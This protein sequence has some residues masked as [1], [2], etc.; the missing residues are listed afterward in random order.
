MA[1]YTI[2]EGSPVIPQPINDNFSYLETYIKN[3]VKE[4]FGSG[5]KLGLSVI[6]QSSPNMT[7]TVNSGVA[8]LPSGLRF[9][10]PQTN[11]TIAN[12]TTVQHTAELH[13]T[14]TDGTFT[15]DLKPITNSNGQ[16]A[17]S[18]NVLVKLV[19]DSSVVAISNITASTGVVD[20]T[21]TSATNVKIDYYHGQQRI[22]VIIINEQGNLQIIQGTPA[23]SNPSVPII[24]TTVL[25]LAEIMVNPKVSIC[26]ENTDIINKNINNGF[27]I[28]V[29]KNL[30]VG[31]D[32]IVLGSQSIGS[33]VNET[34]AVR[35]YIYNDQIGLP[36]SIND[37]LNVTGNITFT[38][39]INGRNIT[40]DGSVL[41]SHLLK[42]VDITS[43]DTTKDKHISN[44][45]ANGWENHR[46]ATGN[47]HSMS[48]NDLNNIGQV[49]ITSA[50]TAKDKH[51]S[52]ALAKAWQDHINS[53]HLSLGE[54]ISTAYRGDRGK[55]AYEHSISTGNPH[56]TT[57]A[58]LSLIAGVSTSSTDT[59]LDKHVS[60][61][62]AKGWEDHRN[63]N[64]NAH[65]MNHSQ[66]NNVGQVDTTST[67]TIKDKHVSNALA[68]GW[69]DHKNASA[70]HSG[71]APIS[72]VGA[73]GTAHAL[74]S[75]NAAGFM[76]SSDYTK[77]SGIEFGATADMT[78]SEILTVLKT[79]DG[80][81]S[82]LDADKVHGI[83]IDAGK[84]AP[85]TP[86]VN[87]LWLDTN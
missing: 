40:N 67:D 58:Q 47:V 7:V 79:V 36:V 43:T 17:T 80:I 37:D 70:P 82:G 26:I 86:Y 50:D 53:A 24:P 59:I 27:Y 38:G 1:L 57:H 63:T 35:D 45:L 15:T 52:N 64:G 74:A 29:N 30:V 44:A 75:A 21:L 33:T 61:A 23:D 3:F 54:T 20:T 4:S 6:A 72:H 69:E 48:H 2:P 66:L 41:D 84:T 76:S 55:I 56:N 12:P 14:A 34:L 73:G 28:D 10:I 18:S 11:L 39:T 8:Y 31:H 62:L 19:S 77:L 83:R 5:I 68:K 71:H 22:D 78:A 42:I 9:T 65:N 32:L 16:Y 60:N 46:I 81:N 85:T 87:D 13:T 49:D 51:V 25:E